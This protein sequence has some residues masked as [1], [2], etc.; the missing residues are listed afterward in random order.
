MKILIADDHE[1]FLKGLE[2][3][4]SDYNPQ[5]EIIT[6]KSYSDIFN[7]L[8]K[9]KGITLLTSSSIKVSI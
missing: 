9:Q 6:A 1:L 5:A 7:I 3:I 4:L 8:L 2:M